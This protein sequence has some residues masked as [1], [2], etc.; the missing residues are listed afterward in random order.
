MSVKVVVGKN[1]LDANEKNA[2][3]L[4][5]VF[6]ESGVRVVNML[7]SPGSGKTSIL[8]KVIP[9]LS[10]LRVAVIEGDIA[11]TRDAERLS[12]LGIQVVQITTLG[13]CHLDASMVSRAVSEIDLSTVDLLFIE[14][15]GNLVCPASFDLGEDLRILVL[16][17]A[18]GSDKPLKY[19]AAF[20]TSQA[21]II[22]KKDLIPYTDFSLES[23]VAEIRS[24]KSSLEIFEVSCRTGEGIDRLCGWIENWAKGKAEVSK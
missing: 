7:G 18:E 10:P 17:V 15:V 14:N 2:D 1:I 11:T 4:R 22:N 24:M 12:S 16:S 20:L 9:G 23:A 5:K 3:D 8:Q 6:H 19:P 21:V 13:A